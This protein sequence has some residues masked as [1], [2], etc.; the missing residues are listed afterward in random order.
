MRIDGYNGRLFAL[1][2]PPTPPKNGRFQLL[3]EAEQIAGH[4]S[5]H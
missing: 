1:P 2:V 3:R 5:A 4:K